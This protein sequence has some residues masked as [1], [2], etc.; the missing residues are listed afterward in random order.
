MAANLQ[1]K[2]DNVTI[3]NE[4]TKLLSE[5]SSGY[6]S[7]KLLRKTETAQSL[8]KNH[9]KVNFLSVPANLKTRTLYYISMTRILLSADESQESEY[10]EF[11]MPFQNVLTQIHS[12]LDLRTI[13]D[14]AFQNM[15]NGVLYD[16]RGFASACSSRKMFMVFF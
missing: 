8:L 14:T 12:S 15:I 5:L 13:N 3:V 6:S 16:L 1:Y 9:D 7:V 2:A 10:I 4:T 11:M